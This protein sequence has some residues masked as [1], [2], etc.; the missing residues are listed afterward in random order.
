MAHK[1]VK[2]L[3][4]TPKLHFLDTGLLAAA[5]RIT[6][7]KIYFTMGYGGAVWGPF[8]CGTD[9]LAV[10]LTFDETVVKNN[11]QLE[12]ADYFHK[13]AMKK[14]AINRLMPMIIFQPPR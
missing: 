8:C 2:R 3:V 4:K 12:H 1:Y 7:A 9:I 5:Q 14:D 13:V 10:A 6:E 11:Q